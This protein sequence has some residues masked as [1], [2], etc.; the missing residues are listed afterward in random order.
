MAFSLWAGR[1]III[2]SLTFLRMFDTSEYLFMF[3]MKYK[4]SFKIKKSGFHT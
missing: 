1:I 2:D 4:Y 3:W